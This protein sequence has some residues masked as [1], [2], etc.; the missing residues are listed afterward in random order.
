MVLVH[1]RDSTPWRSLFI[2]LGLSI[3]RT[4]PGRCSL[5]LWTRDCLLWSGSHQADSSPWKELLPHCCHVQPLC[6]VEVSDSCLCSGSSRMIFPVSQNAVNLHCSSPSLTSGPQE[7][8]MV[9]IPA[10]YQPIEGNILKQLILFLV[11]GNA[12]EVT[13]YS[14]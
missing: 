13:I 8:E 4:D 2:R 5:L 11:E 12:M 14:A 10:E 3:C 9:W 6:G 7:G 1:G